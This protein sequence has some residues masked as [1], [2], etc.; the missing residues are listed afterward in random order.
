LGS[1]QAPKSNIDYH[2]VWSPDGKAMVYVPSST[3]PTV[4][5]PITVTPSVSFGSPVELR[6]PRPALLSTDMRGYD[7]LRDGRVVSLTG[8]PDDTAQAAGAEVRVIL[9]WTE[10]L[11]QR[12]PTR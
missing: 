5:V 10:E 7:V 8:G 1:F 2:P 3:R 11:K 9:N 4:A 6:V 12:V